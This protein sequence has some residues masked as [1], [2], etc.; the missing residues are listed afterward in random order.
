MEKL[1]GRPFQ[2]GN[3]YGRGRPK[4]SRNKITTAWDELQ[5]Q[6]GEAVLRKCVAMALQGDRIALRLC[7]ERLIAIRRDATL[8]LKLPSTRTAKGLDKACDALLQAISRGEVTPEQGE[9]LR[10]ILD[11]RRRII[12]TAELEE[13]LKKLEAMGHSGQDRTYL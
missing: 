13:R 12:E 7:V 8:D 5:G 4:G 9:S 2:P 10:A 3:N 6:Y 1:R 11:S